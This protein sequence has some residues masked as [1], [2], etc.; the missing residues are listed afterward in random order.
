M[1]DINDM[2]NDEILKFIAERDEKS[3]LKKIEPVPFD[4]KRYDEFVEEMKPILQDTIDGKDEDNEHWA[5][6]ASLK[7]VFGDDVFEKLYSKK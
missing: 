3:S 2:T 4:K 5:Y 6:E 1:K 7:L